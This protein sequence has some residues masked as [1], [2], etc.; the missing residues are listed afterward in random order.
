M[1]AKGEGID[2]GGILT[3]FNQRNVS[4]CIIG[5]VAVF[6]HGYERATG[7]LDLIIADSQENKARALLALESLGI[8]A[9][10]TPVG[11]HAHL[12][13]LIDISTGFLAVGFPRAIENAVDGEVDG[14]PCKIVSK[15]HL[16]I[17]KKAVG[18]LRD[19]ND[20]EELE[21]RSQ[22]YIPSEGD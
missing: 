3:A 21:G 9:E 6:F 22:E 1:F 14:V 16:I 11:R 2:I 12:D 7:D 5:G 4:Y 20:V 10:Q 17:N 19:L 8:H 15:A 13:F 18:R